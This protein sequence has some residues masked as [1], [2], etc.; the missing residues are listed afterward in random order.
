M[1]VDTTFQCGN[2]ILERK[3]I[4]MSTKVAERHGGDSAVRWLCFKN[5]EISFPLAYTMWPLILHI[6][7]V[8]PLMSLSDE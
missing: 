7:G 8:P 2:S 6:E 5:L 4:R 1:G 3:D